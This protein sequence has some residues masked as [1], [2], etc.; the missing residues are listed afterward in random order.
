M[1]ALG[2]RDRERLRRRSVRLHELPEDEVD[3]WIEM[4]EQIAAEAEGEFQARVETSYRELL[5]D[6]EDE[7]GVVLLSVELEER[8][9]GYV[10][11]LHARFEDPHHE[12]SLL[13]RRL[14]V[15]RPWEED[16]EG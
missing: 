10:E 7:C 4:A 13:F 3:E 11:S 12:L 1:S 14:V 6:L 9:R 16:Y 5:F 15:S 8:I 2:E